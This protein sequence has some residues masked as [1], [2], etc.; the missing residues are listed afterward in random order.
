MNV[1]DINSL[2]FLHKR[3]RGEG[4]GEAM[5]AR[6]MALRRRVGRRTAPKSTGKALMTARTGIASVTAKIAIPE[7]SLGEAR[8]KLCGDE[9][10]ESGPASR[11][12]AASIMQDEPAR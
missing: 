1:P 3:R 5:Q 11:K 8:K 4:L 7:S 2:I 6:K 9:R 12:A 10:L